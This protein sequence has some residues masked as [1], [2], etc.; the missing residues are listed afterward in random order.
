VARVPLQPPCSASQ[1]ICLHRLQGRFGV[2]VRGMDVLASYALTAPAWAGC[3]DPL[4]LT[5]IM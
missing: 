2:T 5:C 3:V 1:Q 4:D